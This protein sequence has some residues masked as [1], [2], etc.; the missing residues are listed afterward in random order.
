[1]SHAGSGRSGKTR[2]F[3]SGRTRA[4]E[5]F[6]QL[7]YEGSL[8]SLDGRSSRGPVAGGR[9][10]WTSASSSP[11]LPRHSAEMRLR[12]SNTPLTYLRRE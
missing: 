4:G 9:G 5:L 8:S 10:G 12:G 1:M 2:S 7:S 6:R 11:G 3:R